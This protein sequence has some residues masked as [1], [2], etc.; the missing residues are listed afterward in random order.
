MERKIF[1]QADNLIQYTIHIFL[2]EVCS[3]FM[4]IQ[5]SRSRQKKSKNLKSI[6]KKIREGMTETVD[7]CL[8]CY[9]V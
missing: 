7:V 9:I 2:E 8:C 1:W 3:I 6:V 4:F 5:K